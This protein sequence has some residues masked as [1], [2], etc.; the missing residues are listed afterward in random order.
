MGQG[1]AT[2]GNA[3]LNILPVMWLFRDQIT[4]PVHAMDAGQNP[5][6]CIIVTIHHGPDM[7]WRE[8]FHQFKIFAKIF[9]PDSAPDVMIGIFVAVRSKEF[10]KDIFMQR[11]HLLD[12]LTFSRK[13]G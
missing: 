11:K 2:G 10:A 12:L 9:Q 7:G 3:E 6:I 13:L 5:L 4:D 1:I 8:L